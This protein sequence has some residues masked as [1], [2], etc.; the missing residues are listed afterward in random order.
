MGHLSSVREIR[1]SQS[2]LE[3]L[4]EK[5]LLRL[6]YRWGNNTE[7]DLRETVHEP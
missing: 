5:Y 7:K 2:Y 1:N 4:K 3:T 6:I